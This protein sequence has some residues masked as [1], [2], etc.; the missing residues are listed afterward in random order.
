MSGKFASSTAS[1]NGQNISMVNG[2][3]HASEHFVAK[4]S[5]ANGTVSWAEVSGGTSG[6][7]M[8]N[9]PVPP[10]TNVIV[11]NNDNVLLGATFSTVSY[12][13]TFDT[14]YSNGSHELYLVKY[15]SSGAEQ[16][17]KQTGNGLFSAVHTPANAAITGIA[18]DNGTGLFYISGFYEDTIQFGNTSIISASSGANIYAARLQD[19][20]TH[21]GFRK[22]NL[23]DENSIVVAKEIS[24]YPNPATGLV[25]IQNIGS[26]TVQIEISDVRGRIIA[27]KLL[28]K[29]NENVTL[30]VSDQ[31]AGLYLLKTQ[32]NNTVR[33]H[34]LLKQ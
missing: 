21:G 5:T 23:P 34:K 4:C 12:F 33:V 24:V 17:V 7:F 10:H 15:N 29:G 20:V 8:G 18:M 31:P 19:S 30:D 2:T 25:V 13:G 1:I 9:A 22:F 11:D 26:E 14:L 27:Q 16:W 6:I 3:A 32:V 28:I